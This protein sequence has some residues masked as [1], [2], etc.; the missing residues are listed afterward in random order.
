[1]SLDDVV[2]EPCKD[3]H[4]DARRALSV[5]Y[6]NDL[7]DFRAA[8]SKI[9]VLKQDS[10]LA[11]HF[12][13]Y[14]ELF[15][16]L[17][18]SG[19]FTLKD[20]DIP[21]ED[22]RTYALRPGERLLIPPHI[23]HDAFLTK[24]SVL[25]GY[26]EVPYSSPEQN[27]HKY[28]VKEPTTIKEYAF[29]NNHEVSR[30]QLNAPLMVHDIYSAAHQSL[31]I[32]CHDVI[33]EYKGG[34]LLV[35]RKNKPAE[36]ILWCFGGRIN[37]GMT[38]E[39]SLRKRIKGECDLDLENINYIGCARTLFETDPFGHGKGTDSLNLLYFARGIGELNIDKLHEQPRIVKPQDYTPEFQTQLHP[40]VKDFLD[41]TMPR[42]QRNAL[43]VK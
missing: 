37:R 23:A 41:L 19:I 24:G 40:Y 9:A 22:A 43:A 34:A 42:I 38:A 5:V 31:T 2:H 21:T 27:D 13:N 18:G 17:D 28:H 6:N 36:N 29:E 16:L 1:M 14:R 39:E 32:P 7:G 20:V 8:Q 30:D 26:T 15:Y 3:G 12:H 33:I 11:G 25:I 4:E 10:T 35:T